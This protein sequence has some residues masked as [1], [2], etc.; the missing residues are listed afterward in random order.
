MKTK[1]KD[2]NFLPQRI[3]RAR[4]KRKNIFLYSMLTVLIVVF[5]G[6]A[7]WLP[8]QVA[9]V[10]RDKLIDIN[11]EISDLDSAKRYY[12]EMVNLQ[13]E[14]TEKELA[15]EEIESK[16]QKITDIL[17]QINSILPKNCFVASLAIKAKEEFNIT[18]VTNNPVETARVLVG[19]RKMGLFEKVELAGVGDVPFTEGLYPVE[20]KLKFIGASGSDDQENADSEAAE[21]KND[22]EQ[23]MK[24]LQDQVM[25]Q[26]ELGLNQ[27]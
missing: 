27:P 17:K 4:Q 10:Y 5:M 3:I 21:H 8:F 23:Q 26:N 19:L 9:G 20:F 2:I 16:Q 7:V 25:Q 15:L 13:Q 22:L 11:R 14:L 1:V 12:Q 6:G 24:Q 18:V